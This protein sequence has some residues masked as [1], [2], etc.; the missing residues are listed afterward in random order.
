MKSQ[1]IRS[2]FLAFFESKKHQVLAIGT[3]GC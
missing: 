1:D 3:D 2:Q